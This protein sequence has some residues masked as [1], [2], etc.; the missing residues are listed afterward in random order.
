MNC[1]PKY[2]K[3]YI[4][5]NTNSNDNTYNGNGLKELAA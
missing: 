1:W 3:L 2:D 4:Y 5:I